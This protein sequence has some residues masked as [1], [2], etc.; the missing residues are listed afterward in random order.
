MKEKLIIIGFTGS[1]RRNSYN[2]AALFAAKEMLP[3]GVDLEILDISDLPF[4]NEDVEAEG[5]PQSVVNFKNKLNS[6]DAVLISTPE[7]NYSIPP[8]LKNALDWASR[9]PDLPLYG[10]PLAIM[11]AS[12]GIFGGA[13]AQY[14][15]RQVC[16]VLN[17]LPLNAPEVFITNASTKFSEEGKLTD[18]YCRASISKLMQALIDATSGTK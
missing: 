7:Y 3:K 17:M 6:A 1:L 13:R 10:K 15:L 8:V 18:E 9:G 5:I 16:V 4:F 14:H 12:L 2:K 11:S